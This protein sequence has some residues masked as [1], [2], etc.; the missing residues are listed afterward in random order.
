MNT[1]ETIKEL[2]LDPAEDDLDDLLVEET[3]PLEPEEMIPVAD[4]SS[5]DDGLDIPGAELDDEME[6]NGDEDEENN[7][8]SLG[9]ENHEALE[10]D[11]SAD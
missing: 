7:Y 11:H 6:K 1:P 9:G 8:Y 10:E 2:P 4:D 5:L 3:P